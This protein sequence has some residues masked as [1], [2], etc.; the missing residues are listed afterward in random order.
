MMT[1]E[2]Y[3]RLVSLKSSLKTTGTSECL[4]DKI[5]EQNG[6]WILDSGALEHITGRHDF[7]QDLKKIVG[8]CPIT[9]P[10]ST[11]TH[12]TK[13]GC[14]NPGNNFTLSDVHYLP[15][16]MYNLISVGKL[17]KDL[18][19]SITF[20]SSHCILQNITSRKSIGMDD[21]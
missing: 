20:F 12:A 3:Q 11:T 17:T 21:L 7:L 14:V 19:C 16:F 9:T 18:N 10:D 4:K 5:G 6:A 15:N 13:I 8:P 1:E 2:D